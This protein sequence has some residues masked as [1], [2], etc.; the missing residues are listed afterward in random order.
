MTS[1]NSN[2]SNNDNTRKKGSTKQ[3]LKDKKDIK[4][5]SDVYE[6]LQRHGR[7]GQRMSDIIR[8]LLE[9]HEKSGKC[10]HMIQL[11]I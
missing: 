6:K 2:R 9:E 1:S 5:E 4:V 7:Y 3:P 8:M 10:N 11:L